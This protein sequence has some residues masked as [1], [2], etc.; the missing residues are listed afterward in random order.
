MT[1]DEAIAIVQSKADGRTRYQGQEPFLDEV[2]VQEILTLRRKLQW[3]HRNIDRIKDW[4]GVPEPA[5]HVVDFIR[6]SIAEVV[7]IEDD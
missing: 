2:L 6:D 3:V 4:S 5:K 7:D 1:P